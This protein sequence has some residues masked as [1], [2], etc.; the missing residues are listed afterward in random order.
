MIAKKNSRYDLE[1]K[2]FVLL[3]IGLLTAGSL[4]LA[5][6][7]YTSPVHS[8]LEK[9]VVAHQPIEFLTIDKEVEEIKESPVIKDH[10][11]SR[12]DDFEMSQ[13]NSAVSEDSKTK[14]N[15]KEVKKGLEGELG[16][17]E[18]PGDL[19]LNVVIIGDDE[20]DEFPAIPTKYI[21][22]SVAMQLFIAGNVNYPE[23]AQMFNDEGTVYVSF[24]IEKDGSVSH[25]E[26]E[27]GVTNSLDR[28][29]KRLVRSFPNWKPAENAYGA[30]RTRV[31]LPLVFKL[32]GI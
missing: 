7:T 16:L 14:K 9:K 32:D 3:Q 8:E 19:K 5:A 27:R 13:D 6:F 12:S 18:G 2:R 22:G 31:R 11:E 20:V 17:P 25:V 28:E 29:A 24:I 1:R 26:I 10:Q 4:T 23:D 21:G 30:V 15:T